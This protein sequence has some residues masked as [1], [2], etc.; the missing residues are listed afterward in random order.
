MLFPCTAFHTF[1]PT[2]KLAVELSIIGFMLG[3]CIAFFVVC[4]DLGPAIIGPL[5]NVEEPTSIR[6]TVL[7]GKTCIIIILFSLKVPVRD[8][9]EMRI[10]YKILSET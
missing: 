2:G 8:Q 9:T 3:T 10:K 1:G 5:I 7:M 4:G 6:P